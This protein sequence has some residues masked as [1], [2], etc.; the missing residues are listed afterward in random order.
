MVSRYGLA[1]LIERQQQKWFVLALG[2]SGIGLGVL[3]MEAVFSDRPANSIGLTVYVFA[4][5]LVPIAIGIAILRY[6]LY[7]STGS[8]AVDL[9]T[10]SPR[11]SWAWCL[12]AP[13]SFWGPSSGPRGD[14]ETS[15][16][17]GATLVV[18]A[19]F[20]R[21]RGRSQT[22]VDR[23]FDRTR[24]DATANDRRADDA[25]PRRRGPSQSRVRRPG[26]RR[27]RRSIPDQA[28]VWLRRPTNVTDPASR[29]DFRTPTRE[30]GPTMT[31]ITRPIRRLLGRDDT[32]IP[33]RR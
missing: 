8:S 5:A 23:R 15:Q 32:A 4:G 30:D 26:R 18:A 25:T 11:P 9:G 28:T 20:G 22:V 1:G 33:R 24:Y 29:N 17:A 10:A 14:N 7:G 2:V 3:S 12:P 31:D 21:V 13:P 6:Q 19:F 16:V 27:A